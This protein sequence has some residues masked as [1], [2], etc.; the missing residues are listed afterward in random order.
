MDRLSQIQSNAGFTLV[1]L[2]VAIAVSGLI[3]AGLVQV[4]YTTNKSYTKQDQMAIVQQSI[5]F[6]KMNLERDIRMAGCGL[7]TG[8]YCLG[9]QELPLTNTDGGTTGADSLTIS[10]VD[11]DDPCND[12]LPPLT[13]PT[14]LTPHTIIA[15][16]LSVIPPT[17]PPYTATWTA[18]VPCAPAAPFYAIYSYYALSTGNL[19]PSVYSVVFQVTK[20]INSSTLQCFFTVP[21]AGTILTNPTVGFFSSSQLVKVTYSLA[22]T[23]LNRTVNYPLLTAAQVTQQKLPTGG[24]IADNIEDLEFAFGLD[25]NADGTV[26]TWINNAVLTSPQIAQVLQVRV[27][28]VGISSSPLSGQPQNVEPAVEN[29][30]AGTVHDNYLREMFQF[31]VMP[32]NLTG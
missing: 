8:F 25:T 11:Y 21:G 32:R 16:T 15:P 23:T 6:A 31:V 19:P 9:V 26:D 7:G 17:N 13:V 3:L 22:G 14:A 24:A 10:Y 5:R 29:H 2:L 20:V 1:E 30:L 18:G 12:A 4:F 27:S 28:I